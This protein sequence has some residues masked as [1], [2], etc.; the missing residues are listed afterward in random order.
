MLVP[1]P[2]LLLDALGVLL[3][4]VDLLDALGVLLLVV[5]LLR[6]VDVLLRL[7]HLLIVVLSLVS[8][9]NLRNKCFI[10]LLY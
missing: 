1:D 4:V 2:E 3:R 7:V 5:R 6:V 9:R 8:D 10:K